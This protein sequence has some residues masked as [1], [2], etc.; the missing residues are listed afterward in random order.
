M[1]IPSHITAEN[2]SGRFILNKTLSDNPDAVLAIQGIGYLMRK[3]MAM[4]TPQMD[5]HQSTDD[6]G[7]VHLTLAVTVGGKEANNELSMD[8]NPVT[9]EDGPFG[10]VERRS[11]YCAISEIDLACS[12]ANA[13]FLKG[14]TLA[15]GHTPSAWLEEAAGQRNIQLYGKGVKDGWTYEQVWGFEEIGGKRYHTR[16][17]VAVHG[18]KD[19]RARYVYEFVN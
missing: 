16:R 17:I 19:A 1:A 3:T 13:S 12:G 10:A 15:D 14:Q 2:F 11:R 7:T 9:K 5:V 8:W 18:N 4:A 6:S